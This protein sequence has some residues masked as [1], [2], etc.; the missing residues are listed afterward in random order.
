MPILVLLSQNAQSY[1]LAAVLY[2]C[3]SDIKLS[4]NLKTENVESFTFREFQV[5]KFKA[6]FMFMLNLFF[7]KQF[8]ICL[9]LL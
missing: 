2:S 8:M 3:S 1:P 6:V 9:M 4:R 5:L 7:I